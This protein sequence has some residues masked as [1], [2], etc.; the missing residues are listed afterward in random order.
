MVGSDFIRGGVVVASAPTGFR[1]RCI[2]PRVLKHAGRG[3]MGEMVRNIGK[4]EPKSG[5]RGVC[6][7]NPN[8][9][10]G[11]QR[12]PRFWIGIED[13]GLIGNANEPNAVCGR[14][15]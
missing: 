2:G 12:K 8:E 9:P 10:N 4:N 7:T 1:L 3:L 13:L 11:T 6:E 5:S 15:L 14:K